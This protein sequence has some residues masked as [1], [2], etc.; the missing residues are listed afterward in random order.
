[1]GVQLTICVFFL[2]NKRYFKVVDVGCLWT[3]LKREA[4]FLRV[5]I[6]VSQQIVPGQVTPHLNRFVDHLHS[7]G[8]GALQVLE[9]CALAGRNI[10]LDIDLQVDDICGHGAANKSFME[11]K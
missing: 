5:F 9:K 8:V 7:L 3:H 10:P 11:K 4:V 1:M 6:K 2:Q